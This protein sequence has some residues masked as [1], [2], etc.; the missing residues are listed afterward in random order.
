MKRGALVQRI[1]PENEMEKKMMSMAAV[2]IEENKIL[3]VLLDSI[4]EDVVDTI[5][6]DPEVHSQIIGEISDFFFRLDLGW[7]PGAQAESMRMLDDLW[8]VR[9][10]EASLR[11]LEDILKQGHRTK[12]DLLKNC[13][14]DSDL[15]SSATMEKFKQ[16]F[17]FDFSEETEMKL[18][19]EEFR[20][21]ARWIQK[22]DRFVGACGILAWDAARFVHLSRL[23][24]IA[25]YLTEAEAWSEILKM[26]PLTLG[27][28][29]DWREFALSFII[30]RTFWIGGEDPDIKKCCERLLGHPLSPWQFFDTK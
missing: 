11:N 23:S 3:D 7:G 8:E 4:G 18:S 22:T 30:G 24:Y 13:V 6:S 14:A 1:L 5:K 19:D 15:I 29:K 21:L 25:G 28:F 27:K 16:I 20:L 2:F 10:R 17:T 12:F 26:A 9:S